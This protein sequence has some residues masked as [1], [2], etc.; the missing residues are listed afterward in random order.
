MKTCIL[1]LCCFA[2]PLFYGQSYQGPAQG[3]VPHGVVISTDQFDAL[4][5]LV[6]PTVRA[7]RN[8]Q[9]K[10]QNEVS[11][12]FPGGAYPVMEY[13]DD[14]LIGSEGDSSLLLRSFEGLTE[15]NSIPPDAH[16]AAGPTQI[17]GTVNS[18]FA[19]WDKEGNLLKRINADVFYQSLLPGASTFDPKVVYDQ[20]AKRFIMVWLHVDDAQAQS[21]FIISVSDDST[22]TGVWYNWSL[23][24][25]LNGSTYAS[26]WGDYQGVGF[27]QN[28]LYI[29]ADQF[30]FASEYDYVKIRVIPK[31]QLLQNNAGPVVWQD[32]WDITYPTNS[33]RVFNIR[34]SIVFTQSDSYPLLHAPYWSANYVTLYRISNPVSNPVL[35]AV[36]VPVAPYQGSPNAGQPGGG[37]QIETNGSMLTNEPAYRDGY[38]YAVHGIAN[39]QSSVYASARFLKINTTSAQ[40]VE[41]KVLGA[42]GYWYFYPAVTVDK[43]GNAVV[44][45]SRS[46]VTEYPGAYYSIKRSGSTM[47]L[48][49]SNLLKAGEGQYVKD[50]GSGRNRWGDY[51]GM[52][53]DPVTE[54]NFW[55]M[56]EFAKK[57]NVWSNWIGEVRVTPVSGAFLVNHTKRI[58]FGTKDVTGESLTLPVTVQNAGSVS[59]V[60]T[61]L[62][63]NNSAFTVV[64]SIQFPY[65]IQPFDSLKLNVRFAPSTRGVFAD[66]LHFLGSFAQ[67]G[68][69]VLH[70]T[71]YEINPAVSRTLYALSGSAD[72]EKVYTL[73]KENA[74][75]T[76]IGN[77]FY[78]NVKPAG[79]HPK[80]QVAYGFKSDSLTEIVRIN[81]A[82]GDAYRYGTVRI[83]Q[84]TA[85]AFDTSGALYAVTAKNHLYRIQLADTT[86]LYLDS[87]KCA[88]NSIVF[89]PNSN[90]LF[91]AAY[92]PIGTPRD[93]I[94]R[95]NTSNGDT[96]H[97]CKTGKNAN[98]TGMAF[99]ENGKLFA[100]SGNPSQN[101]ILFEI[102]TSTGIVTDIGTTS[103]KNLIGLMYAGNAVSSVSDQ[104][105]DLVPESLILLQNYPNPFNAETRISY[106]IG[107]QAK[108]RFEIYNLL[109]ERILSR[110]E[111]VREA[112]VHSFYWR[113]V[114]D[115]GVAL[116][117]G[118]YFCK[119]SA[120]QS[121]REYSAIIKLVLLK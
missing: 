84:I 118:V 50:Y 16:L 13:T 59:A 35:T 106:D 5:P 85:A 104:S 57:N 44:T 68:G 113:G 21:Y 33:E 70:G 73:N 100:S 52:A 97:V 47:G 19:I 112:G 63:V 38:L 25:S 87:V 12:E 88:V 98:T 37:L 65:T 109:G 61:G 103:V 11:L 69:T 6:P 26:N 46:G 51:L 20:F 105:A 67:Q 41:D 53:L 60:L 116:P 27:D 81:A 93:L 89:H 8:K 2:A 55:M 17:C 77:L 9:H 95:I 49:P 107:S 79:I 4:S 114:N 10:P 90:E 54:E 1:L 94:I 23:N 102:Q 121:D 92:R 39:P 74:S 115:Y 18:D 96:T 30:S 101:S 72:G 56:T 78:Q 29:T 82:L 32:I 24:S 3:G 14:R 71:G 86:F 28:A 45:Y 36:N 43:H 76:S 64:N 75:S 83:G 40:A 66:T 119:V 34:P 42:S 48:T 111:G 7:T 31:D 91:G 22:A 15:T 58:N 110:Q 99:D 120:V 62:I 80:T 117:G 108:V